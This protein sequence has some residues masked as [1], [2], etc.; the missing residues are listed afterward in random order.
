MAVVPVPDV[1]LRLPNDVDRAP[2][3]NRGKGIQSII[4]PHPS[5]RVIKCSQQRRH[6]LVGTY[7]TERMSGRITYFSVPILRQG[8]A[9]RLN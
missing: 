6:R 4:I 2:V 5:G 3:T 9:Q 1:V 8:A 7:G